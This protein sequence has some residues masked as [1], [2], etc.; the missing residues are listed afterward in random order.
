[1][2]WITILILL[3]GLWLVSNL[4][5][6]TRNYLAARK[7]GAPIFIIPWNIY[8]PLWMVAAVP[9]GV[10]LQKYI[11][12]SWRLGLDLGTY[13]FEFRSKEDIFV[14]KG[15]DAVVLVTSG[16][17]EVS[18]RDPEVSSEV[19]KRPKDFPV[20]DVVAVIMNVFGPNLISS[21]GEDWTR[22]RKLVS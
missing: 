19:L 8:N 21:N 4:Y 20:T 7:I 11:P 13:G 12:A 14:E 9:L 17:V 16:P 15:N 3:V 10:P 1:M 18:I 5:S 6:L 22:Q 2:A